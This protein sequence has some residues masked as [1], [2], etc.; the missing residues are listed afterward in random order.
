MG[1]WKQ[2]KFKPLNPQKYKGDP[3]D[4]VYRSRW[5]LILMNKFDTHPDVLEWSSETIIIPYR[6]PLDGKIHRYFP[7]FWVK[8]RG[9][10]DGKIAEILIEVKPHA[11]TKEPKPVQGK[12]TKRMLNEIATWG[13]NSAKWR[14][15]Q[16]YCANKGWKFEIITEKELGLELKKFKP[17]STKNK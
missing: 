6:S 13:V 17:L 1:K 5:E 12:P 8:R 15:A 14:S 7:D 2:G 9:A 4:I 11:Q 10:S 16:V 3:T